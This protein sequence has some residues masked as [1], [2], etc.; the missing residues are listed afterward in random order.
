MRRP[1]PTAEGRDNAGIA[2]R[3]AAKGETAAE[4]A[5]MAPGLPEE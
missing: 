5:W 4:A 3:G 2:A 1:A